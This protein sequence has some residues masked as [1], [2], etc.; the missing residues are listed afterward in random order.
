MIV[1]GIESSCD[2]T[3]AAVVGPSGV[4]SDI[5]HG[6]AIHVRYGGVVPEIASRAHAEQIVPTVMA[7]LEQAGI[8]R[9]DAVA[10]T[11]GPGLI[12]AVLVGMCFGKAA[13][14]GWGV[15]FVAV[16]HLEGHL[17]SPLLDHP[18]LGFPFLSL[19]VSGG[20]TTLYLAR[21]LGQYQVLAETVDDAAGECFDKVARVCGLGYPGGPHIDRLAATGD[22]RAVPLPR[23]RLADLNMSFSGLKTAARLHMERH[24]DT[25]PADLAASFQQAVVDV[26]VDRVRRAA[27]QTGVDRICIGGGVAANSGVRAGIS[28]SGLRAYLP[29]R[30][31][32]TDNA[33]MIALVGRLYALEGRYSPLSATA[34][35][36]WAPGEPVVTTPLKADPPEAAR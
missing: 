18:D 4:M 12:G 8:T 22:P 27:R 21:G 24:P 11:A 20:H 29:P 1:L 6:Q 32:C 16:N 17:L 19:V 35:P 28:N 14:I 34:R 15:P 36:R 33:A 7:A 31:R 23:P 2:E 9:P 25:P 10:A 13:A 3:A 5:V 30:H 26:L